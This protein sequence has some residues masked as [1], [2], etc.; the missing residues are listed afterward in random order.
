MADPSLFARVAGNALYYGAGYYLS[1]YMNGPSRKRGIGG[2]TFQ[3]KFGG[4][5]KR[6]RYAKLDK[7]YSE[8]VTYAAVAQGPSCCYL[9]IT[10]IPTATL[11]GNGHTRLLADICIGIW[12]DFFRFY[13]P[14]RY[15][16]E[17]PDQVLSSM[18]NIVNEG[19]SLICRPPDPGSGGDSI[20]QFTITVN[21]TLRDLGF[22]L[23]SAMMGAWR[24]GLEPFRL[25]H[26][27][28]VSPYTCGGSMY[29][30]NI[31]VKA[32][33]TNVVTIQNQSL[34]DDSTGGDAD[35]NTTVDVSANPLKGKMFYMKHIAPEISTGYKYEGADNSSTADQWGATYLKDTVIGTLQNIIS[36]DQTATGVPANGCWKIIPKA[37]YFKNCTG[38]KDIGLEPGVQKTFKLRF[39]FVGPLTN[40][41]RGEFTNYNAVTTTPGQGIAYQ[42]AYKMGMG[43]CVLLA[44]EKRLRQT[45]STVNI[46]YQVDSYIKTSVS[47]KRQYMTYHVETNV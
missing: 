47:K 39:R 42:P 24:N 32:K 45:G 12:R 46:A 44:F 34:A 21:T 14:G 36:P 33:V 5:P 37:D 1:R 23:A 15:E 6:P 2:S 26:S 10:S 18:I 17:T 19:Y 29:L 27:V 38:V 43:Q 11:G 22:S 4:T 13:H 25:E 8:K 3:G 40:Y 30:N 7:G 16:F 28:N 9:G 35:A 31:I 41:L 20:D